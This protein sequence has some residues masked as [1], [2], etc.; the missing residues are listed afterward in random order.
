MDRE[1]SSSSVNTVRERS[2]IGPLLCGKK[3]ISPFIATILLIAFTI[4]IAAFLKIWSS[5]TSDIVVPMGGNVSAEASCET[6]ALKIVSCSFVPGDSGGYTLQMLVKNSGKMAL[7]SFHLVAIYEGD[8]VYD[9]PPTE[10]GATLNPVEYKKL[11]A[12]GT[13]NSTSAREVLIETET[14]PNARDSATACTVSA[15]S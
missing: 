2:L 10:G 13:V 1:K 15:P 9:Y 5:N 11:I 12:T 3:G 8:Q 7:G 14:C 6:A 4:A